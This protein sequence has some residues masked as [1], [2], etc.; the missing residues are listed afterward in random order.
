M[1]VRLVKLGG[2]LPG[3]WLPMQG[4]F[5]AFI[6]IFLLTMGGLCCLM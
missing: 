2:M 4:L 6:S 5:L 3:G 1:P